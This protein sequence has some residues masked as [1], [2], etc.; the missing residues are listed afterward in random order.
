MALMA[1]RIMEDSQKHAIMPHA[2]MPQC[3][4]AIWRSGDLAIWRSGD[5]AMMPKIKIPKK[6]TVKAGL[7]SAHITAMKGCLAAQKG[8]EGVRLLQKFWESPATTI[9]LNWRQAAAG[10][11]SPKKCGQYHLQGRV[12]PTS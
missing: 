7:V 12:F 6:I 2:Q 3:D 8:C 1:W 4:L 11:V 10:S 9:V 5:L